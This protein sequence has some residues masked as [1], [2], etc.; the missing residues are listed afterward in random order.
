[1]IHTGIIKAQ[2]DYIRWSE[3]GLGHSAEYLIVTNIAQIIATEKYMNDIQYIYVEKS[4]KE[5][6]EEEELQENS[7]LRH[8]RCDICIEDDKSYVIIEVKNTL[9]NRGA[10]YDS[11]IYDIERIETFLQNKKFIKESYICFLN[12]NNIY[13]KDDSKES[14]REITNKIQTRLIEFKEDITTKFK[15]LK[16]TFKEKT[17]IEKNLD[18]TKNVNAGKIWAWQ[19][20]VAKIQLR[21]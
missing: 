16:F 7:K 19:S 12:A 11:I 6:A 17:F 9:T 8:G 10:K 14:R 21:D 20:V 2:K 5:L 4:I 15:N 3:M 13:D 1:M 18:D